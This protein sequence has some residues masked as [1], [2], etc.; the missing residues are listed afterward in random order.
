MLRLASSMLRLSWCVPWVIMREIA[1]AA[2][3]THYRVRAGD[4]NC[5]AAPAARTVNPSPVP[6]RSQ[7]DY[8][9]VAAP[10]Q[11]LSQP[12]IAVT[13]AKQENTMTPNFYD[14][15]VTTVDYQIIFTKRDFEAVLED[16]TT[17]VAKAMTGSGFASWKIAEFIRK[18][19]ASGIKPIPEE[20]ENEDVDKVLEKGPVQRLRRDVLEYL[21]VEYQVLNTLERKQAKYEE[22]KVDA[23]QGIESTLA[24]LKPSASA[25][26]ASLPI[27][28]PKNPGHLWNDNG[29]FA[30]S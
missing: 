9:P 4:S 12:V 6:P 27:T 11:S 3:P 2:L 21:Q 26:L 10:I 13:P 25:L 5:F 18:T 14:Y 15:N 22:D 29:N 30:V 20:W 24:T 7:T 19:D 23:L 1:D 17:T 8:G 28:K 16:G